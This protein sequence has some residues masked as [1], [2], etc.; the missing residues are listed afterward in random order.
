M[1]YINRVKVVNKTYL[2]HFLF[3]LFAESHY[4]LSMWFARYFIYYFRF[5]YLRIIAFRNLLFHQFLADDA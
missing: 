1:P 4:Q 3:E 5:L 2:N